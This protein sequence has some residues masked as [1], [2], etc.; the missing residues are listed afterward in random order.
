MILL[1]SEVVWGIFS[2]AGVEM[3][4][5]GVVGVLNFSLLGLVRWF[6]LS[7]QYEPWSCEGSLAER[8]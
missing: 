4:K 7:L 5:A 6:W 1:C 2:A 8:I 3:C